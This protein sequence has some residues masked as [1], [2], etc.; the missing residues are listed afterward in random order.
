MIDCCFAVLGSWIIVRM[1]LQLQE[2]KLLKLRLYY[3]MSYMYVHVLRKR[4]ALQV[5]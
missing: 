4:E 2:G 3:R 5:H 1:L